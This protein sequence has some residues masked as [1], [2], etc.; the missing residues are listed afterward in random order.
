MRRHWAIS[1]PRS[2][3]MDRRRCSGSSRI[4]SIIAVATVSA[5]WSP[6]RCNSMVN[7]V[8]R[9]TRVP[10]ALLLGPTIRS[11]SA[12]ARPGQR[13]RRGDH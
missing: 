6:G 2:H 1:L 3:V 7:R 13:L 10:M 9:S 11:P 4:A 8:L 5:V 12:R